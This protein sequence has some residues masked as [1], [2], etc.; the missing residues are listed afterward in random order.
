M[1]T[2]FALV[3][4]LWNKLS[5]GREPASL[6]NL[7]V[8]FCSQ[9]TC[10]AGTLAGLSAVPLVRCDIICDNHV[11]TSSLFLAWDRKRTECRSV[12]VARVNST[13]PYRH[14]TDS[15]TL[16]GLF[17]PVIVGFFFPPSH[18]A[19]VCQSSRACYSRV[20][21]KGMW[22]LCLNSVPRKCDLKEP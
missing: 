11:T 13:N 15:H 17:C 16:C 22:C 5:K 19:F 4:R 21:V 7:M 14:M 6:V 8:I 3:P 12:L 10:L 18:I 1:R 20:L 9:F 2:A